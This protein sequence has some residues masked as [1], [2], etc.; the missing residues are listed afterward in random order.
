MV[1]LEKKK[2]K[3]HLNWADVTISIFLQQN[4]I[5]LIILEFNFYF[6]SM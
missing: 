3:N 5:P 4:F 2:K 1:S 6:L